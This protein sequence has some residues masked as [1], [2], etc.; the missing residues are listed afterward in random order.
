MTY[1]GVNGKSLALWGWWVPALAI[2]VG[3]GIGENPAI[4]QLIPDDTLGSESSIV[5]PLNALRDRID[6]GAIRG[7]NLFHSFQEFNIDTGRGAFFDNPAAIENILTRVTGGN[8]SEIFG[9]LGVLGNANLFLVNPSGIV[10]GPDARLDV[11][12]S[13]FASTAGG[14]LFPDGYEFS[15]TNPDV[16][17]LLTVNVPIGLQFGANPGGIVH[18][19]QVTQMSDGEESVV[20]LQVPLGE[21]LGLLGGEIA[22]Q[23]GNV[24]AESGRVELGSVG[25]NST[26]SLTPI[27]AGFAVGYDRVENFQDIQ[28]VQ[29]ALVD[30]SGESGGDVQ[31]RANQLLLQDGGAIVA[32][33]SGEGQAGTLDIHAAES[34]QLIGTVPNSTSVSGLSASTF[35]SGN[36]GEISINTGQ[37]TILD[38][39]AIFLNSLNEGEGGRAGTLNVNATKSVEL[40]G[41]MTTPDRIFRSGVFASTVGM[42][43][44]GDVNINTGQLTIRDGATILLESLLGE[45]VGGRG[46]TLTIDAGESVEIIGSDLS[47]STV[48]I[49]DAGEVHI[50][51]GQL[52]LQ[53]GGN[54]FLTSVNEGAGGR[55]GTLNVNATESVELSG[56]TPDG[57]SSSQIFANTLGLG[58]AGEINIDTRRL[59]LRDGA[60]IFL[61]SLNQGAGGRAGTLNI[62]ATDSVELSGTTSDGTSGSIVFASTS[63]MGDAGEVN[64]NTGRLLLQDGAN[65]VVV[66]LGEG[67]G[68]KLNVNAT[69]SVELVG[70]TPDGSFRS[71]FEGFTSGSGNAGNIDITT[72]QLTLRDGA[73]ISLN[74]LNQEGVG[75]SGTLTVNATESVELMGTTP[76]GTLGSEVFA[77]NNGIR[78]GGTIDITTGRLIVRD[79]ATITLTTNGAGRGGN[80]RVN[81]RESVEVLGTTRVPNVI[82]TE[83]DRIVARFNSSLASS[84]SGTGDGGTI[85]ITTGRLIVRD[86]AN[87]SVRTSGEG[88]GGTLRVNASESV[89]LIGVEAEPREIPTFQPGAEPIVS[90]LTLSSQLLAN[91]GDIGNAGEIE[92]DTRRLLI[93]DGAGID[94]SSLDERTSGRAGTLTVNATESVELTGTTPDGT[95]GSFVFSSTRGLGDGG[96]VII[97]TR[98]LLLQDG[99]RI[100]LFSSNLE[101]GGRAG[102]LTV[103]ATKSVELIGTTA[104]PQT[105]ETQ[106][107]DTDFGRSTGIV[108]S[109]ITTNT[110]GGGDAGEI[111]INTGRLSVRDGAD[112][113]VSTAGS[114]RAG[115]LTVNATESV[116]VVGVA[117]E[118]S[119]LTIVRETESG[120]RVLTNIVTQFSGLL[121]FSDETGDAGNITIQT[122]RLSVRDGAAISVSAENEGQG[123]TLTVN[124]TEFVELIG[125]FEDFEEED[126]PSVLLANNFGAGDAGE[127]TISTERLS[128]RDGGSI[129]LNAFGSGRG[130]T[131]TVNATESVELLG[132]SPNGFPSGLLA[133]TR[134]QGN[135]GS[136]TVNTG[137]LRVADGADISVNSRLLTPEELAL[138]PDLEIQGVEIAE[139]VGNPGSIDITADDVRLENGG[140]L[141]AVSSTGQGGNI[142]VRARD[143]RLRQGLIT[144]SGRGNDPTLDGN[145]DIGAETLVL[146][147]NSQIITSS[148]DPQ[149]GSNIRFSPIDGENGSLVLLQSPDSLINAQGELVIEGELDPDPAEI[150]DIE[151]IDA[152]SL[153]GT[154]FCSQR[155]ESEFIY[156]GRG[157]IP[158]QPSDPASPTTVWQDWSLTEIPETPTTAATP[159]ETRLGGDR[160]VEAQGWYVN[161]TGQVVLTANPVTTTPH[162][163][164]RMPVECNSIDSTA[165]D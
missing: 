156:T 92:I 96:A 46:G 119:E 47:V 28:L 23:G 157:G 34:V 136:I 9:T 44:A 152:A 148:T 127:I 135:G 151:T 49:G 67:S 90:T 30:T 83:S 1:S 95:A 93:Q 33:T 107:N 19:S 59:S 118:P 26:V 18:Q 122:G 102:S 76:D 55:A 17:P 126:L 11:G 140:L 124:A 101:L 103:N 86:G 69:E 105:E 87:I 12:G 32:N 16:P 38:G 36:A 130:G 98:R 162:Q 53:D 159:V 89:E 7:G 121:A 4:A 139:T 97:N 68:G 108:P 144:A 61:N 22:L 77:I 154:D 3:S 150:P 50:N 161:E 153:L 99:A 74:S 163:S 110:L 66:T 43:D 14:I 42:G 56:T 71:G 79:G 142:D 54:L 111:I 40:N 41:F 8:P 112:I 164:G 113:S 125:S 82:D 165:I 146:L 73:N 116:E 65:I 128:L 85:D 141:D 51:T 147:D 57:T 75:S 145:I 158:P 78:D 70:T 100:S 109:R 88:R 62:N 72:G 24:T 91:A 25:G 21:T 94:L 39:A 6:G 129:F 120:Q 137:Q 13:F 143:I 132:T 117:A 114:G 84:T 155:R 15:A 37:L 48:G 134:S 60:T 10:F 27:N 133:R 115:T 123:G 131:L 63:G 20:G 104:V 64:I 45:G 81:A 52:L 106:L 29:E 5:T 31:V 58:N 35:S 160:L 149:G 2:A 80:L 138:A